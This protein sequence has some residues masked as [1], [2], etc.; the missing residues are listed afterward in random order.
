MDHLIT[1]PDQP[2]KWKMD[3]MKN[4]LLPEEAEK[5]G[6]GED[7]DDMVD[8]EGDISNKDDES[9]D[10]DGDDI[11]NNDIGEEIWLADT[12]DLTKVMSKKGSGPRPKQDNEVVFSFKASFVSDNLV[13]DQKDSARFYIDQMQIKPFGLNQAL[14]KMRKGEVAFIKMQKDYSF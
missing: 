13:F 14:K 1:E 9:S 6:A 7:S 12:C 8:D 4:L 10:T 3:Y 2:E 11:M 5:K